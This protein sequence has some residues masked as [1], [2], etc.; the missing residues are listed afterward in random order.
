MARNRARRRLR[1]I[2]AAVLPAHAVDGHD[3]VLIARTGTLNRRYQALIGDLEE[4][5]RR[6]GTWRE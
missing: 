2:S 5:L 6:L 3:Y 4:G 1:A